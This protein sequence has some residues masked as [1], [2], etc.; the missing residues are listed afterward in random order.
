MKLLE[1]FC[2]GFTVYNTWFEGKVKHLGTGV[3]IEYLY[4][5]PYI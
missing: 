2:Q 5:P 3:S 1:A 4:T